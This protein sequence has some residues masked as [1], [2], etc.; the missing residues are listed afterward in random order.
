MTGCRPK[1]LKAQGKEPCF[2]LGIPPSQKLCMLG[3]PN[4]AQHLRAP[5]TCLCFSGKN[6]MH[7]IHMPGTKPADC[8]PAG[9]MGCQSLLR[10]ASPEGSV[11]PDTT[12][13]PSRFCHSCQAKRSCLT[14]PAKIPGVDKLPFWILSKVIFFLIHCDSE[15]QKSKDFQSRLIDGENE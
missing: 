15:R 8:C 11:F 2:T 4:S 9:D 6:E 5:L 1:L 7:L 13:Y 10:T 3:H 14:L 12:A